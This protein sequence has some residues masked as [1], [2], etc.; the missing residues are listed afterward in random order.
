[1]ELFVL[2]NTIVQDFIIFL[3]LK[4]CTILALKLFLAMLHFVMCFFYFFVLLHG[5]HTIFRFCYKPLVNLMP[6]A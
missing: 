6:S 5:I 1:M 4:L 3:T 2:L